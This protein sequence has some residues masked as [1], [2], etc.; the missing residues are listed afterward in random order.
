MKL[1]AYIMM[2]VGFLWIAAACLDLFGSPQHTLWMWHSKN[3]PAGEMIPRV[4]AVS[5]MRDMALSI[6]DSYQPLIIPASMILLGGILNGRKRRKDIEH[7]PPEERV[8]A[9]RP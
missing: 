1:T 3:L 6:Q 7:A 9:P 5:S 4:N 8:E 2:S